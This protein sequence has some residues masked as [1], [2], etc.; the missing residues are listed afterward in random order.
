MRNFIQRVIKKMRRTLHGKAAPADHFSCSKANLFGENLTFYT[1][2]RDEFTGAALRDDRDYFPQDMTE[3]RTLFEM[4]HD[5]DS[6]LDIGGNIGLYGSVLGR[7][8]PRSQIVSVEPDPINFALYTLNTHVNGCRNTA[9]FNIALGADDGWLKFYRNIRNP[10]DS[11]SFKP[12]GEYLSQQA[13]KLT[14]QWVRKINARQ[15]L[16]DIRVLFPGFGPQ[17]VKIDTQGADIVILETLLPLLAMGTII[18]LEL[19]PHHLRMA[20]TSWDKTISCLTHLNKIE[21][22]DIDGN[23]A[24]RTPITIEEI[25]S[26]L[27]TYPERDIGYWDLFLSV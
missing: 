25:K 16:E 11:L 1:H 17:I 21:R 8:C 23:A 4:V 7:K 19:S 14:E 27:Q 15:F 13:T 9:G 24:R 12:P 2:D 26:F 10:G 5:G 22:L 6:I 18:S 3:L 20:G